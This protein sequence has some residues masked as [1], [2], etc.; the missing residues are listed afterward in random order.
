MFADRR[1]RRHLLVTIRGG[2]DV[3]D[4][5][6]PDLNPINSIKSQSN[7]IQVVRQGFEP[8][9][10]PSETV[11]LS[12]QMLIFFFLQSVHQLLF[13]Q[14]KI[15]SKCVSQLFLKIGRN[16]LPPQ[17]PPQSSE[18]PFR[19]N[20]DPLMKVQSCPMRRHLQEDGG[21][22]HTVI[23]SRFH[24]GFFCLGWLFYF[25]IEIFRPVIKRHFHWLVKWSHDPVRQSV[26][27]TRQ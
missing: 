9:L 22:K 8:P 1:R 25:T 14:R 21:T 24:V 27:M 19:T 10:R 17:P 4:D 13:V 6:K 18:A 7:T 15:T 26:S 16:L 11:L 20:T 2:K 5:H 12:F 3:I 23:F